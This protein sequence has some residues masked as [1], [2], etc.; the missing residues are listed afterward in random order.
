VATI[1]RTIEDVGARSVVLVIVFEPHFTSQFSQKIEGFSQ[2]APAKEVSGSARVPPFSTRSV[3][4]EPE[5]SLARAR[6]PLRSHS[7]LEMLHLG[8]MREDSEDCF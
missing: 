6:V 7:C 8:E 5:S 3:E 4:E 2:K 1:N